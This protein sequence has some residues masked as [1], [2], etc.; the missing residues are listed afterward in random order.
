MPTPLKA[1]KSLPVAPDAAVA[2]FADPDYLNGRLAAA[3][4]T[5]PKIVT[6]ERSGDELTLV[7]EQAIPAGVLPS[8][9]SSLLPGDVQITRTEKWAPDGSGGYRADFD[10]TIKNAPASLKGT[11]T[12]TP[13]GSGSTLTVDGQATVP[14][15]FLGGKIEGVIVE[16]VGKLLAVEEKYAAE[17]LP[18]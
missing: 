5:D 9:V 11:M 2:A 17:Q 12:L 3:G 16:Q 18:K 7:T 8:V 10:V 15:P 13:A 14:I 4:G 1:E 6:Q